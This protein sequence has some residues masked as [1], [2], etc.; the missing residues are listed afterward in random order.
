MGKNGEKNFIDFIVEAQTEKKLARG[1]IEAVTA[2][3]LNTYFNTS[4]FENITLEDCEKLIKVKGSLGDN[5][6]S[7]KQA[8]Y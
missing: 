1:F 3:E 2:Q 7:A 5:V 6:L 4:G 8:Y